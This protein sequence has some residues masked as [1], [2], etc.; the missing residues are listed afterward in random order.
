MKMKYKL[1]AVT[2]VVLLAGS[3]PAMAHHSIAQ[4]EEDRT[5]TLNGTVTRFMWTNPHVWIF[6]NVED[7]ETGEQ[8]EWRVEA[9]SPVNLMGRGG[10]EASVLEPGQ[11][12]TV[13]LRPMKDGTPLGHFL[14]VTTNGAVL[15]AA[16]G[17]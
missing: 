8:V 4:Y 5:V 14:Q 15:S 9:G 11:D 13:I 17:Y 3:G 16:D 1:L 10:W 6:M 7:A 2:G 12:V